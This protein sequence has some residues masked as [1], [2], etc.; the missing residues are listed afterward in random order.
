MTAFN[1][2]EENYI[3]ASI[4]FGDAIVIKYCILYAKHYIYLRK[5]KIKIKKKLI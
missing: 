3:H 5:L 4:L 2:Q 1:I